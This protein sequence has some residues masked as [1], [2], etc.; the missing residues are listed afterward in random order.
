MKDV[1]DDKGRNKHIQDNRCRDNESRLYIKI[2]GGHVF[3]RTMTC[4]KHKI[5]MIDDI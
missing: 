3:L 4:L 1:Q 5:K 2:N